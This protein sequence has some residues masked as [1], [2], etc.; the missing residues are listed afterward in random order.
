MI[1]LWKN[2]AKKNKTLCQR[3]IKELLQEDDE[4]NTEEFQKL[5]NSY[6]IEKPPE[7]VAEIVS[8]IKQNKAATPKLQYKRRNNRIRAFKAKHR[9]GRGLAK[10]SYKY[11]KEPPLPPVTQLPTQGKG[12]RITAYL[13]EMHAVTLRDWNKVYN[14]WGTKGPPDEIEWIKKHGKHLEKNKKPNL[15]KLPP[16]TGEDLHKQIR[17]TNKDTAA[18]TCGWRA[19]ELKLLPA[20]LLEPYA[21]LLDKIEKGAPWPQGLLYAVVALLAKHGVIAQNALQQ[22]PITISSVLYRIYSSLRYKHLCLWVKGWIHP[23]LKGGIP[24]GEVR[25]ITVELGIDLEQTAAKAA[26][27]EQKGED[28]SHNTLY[29]ANEDV[30][31]CYDTMNRKQLF[32]AATKLGADETFMNSQERFYNQLKRTFRY[33]RSIGPWFG[34]QTSILQG[35]ALSQHWVNIDAS[36]WAWT[37]Q[38]AGEYDKYGN[39]KPN[40]NG[41]PHLTVNG[42]IDDKGLRG[43]DKDRGQNGVLASD[44]YHQDSGQVPEYTK[45][46]AWHDSPRSSFKPQPLKFGPVPLKLIPMEKVLGVEHQY[47]G[48]QTRGVQDERGDKAAAAAK[49]VAVLPITT[50]LKARLIDTAV[51]PVY[52][53]GAEN[54]GVIQK[55]LDSVTRQVDQAIRGNKYQARAPELYWALVQNGPRIHPESACDVTAVRET[56]RILQKQNNLWNKVKETWTTLQELTIDTKV[57]GPIGRLNQIFK[58]R[59]WKWD[60]SFT[61]NQENGKSLNLKN[62]HYKH[63]KEQAEEASRLRLIQKFHNPKRRVRKDMEGLQIPDFQATTALLKGRVPYKL[64]IAEGA[65]KTILGSIISGAFIPLSGLTM[66]TCWHDVRCPFCKMQVRENK[67]H[68]FWICPAW[69]KEREPYINMLKGRGVKF[70]KDGTPSNSEF[71]QAMLCCGIINEDPQITKE[72]GKLKAEH[73]TPQPAPIRSEKDR[74]KEAREN[75]RLKAASDGSG[76][77]PREGR[78]R[79]CGYS[80]YFGP[81]HP[82]NVSLPL[83]GQ[84]QTTPRAEL[85]AIL[86]IFPSL[87]E[88]ITL[89]VDCSYVVNGYHLLQETGEVPAGA[90]QDLWKT[91]KKQVSKLPEKEW[92]EVQK[93]NAHLTLKDVKQGKITKQHFDLNE[94]A[95]STAKEGAKQNLVPE[96]VAKQ[97]Y[98]RVALATIT[99]KMFLKIIMTRKPEFEELKKKFPIEKEGTGERYQEYLKNTIYTKQQEKQISITMERGDNTQKFGFYGEW[100]PQQGHLQI[101]TVNKGSIAENAGLQIDDIILGTNQE[102]MIS[103]TVDQWEKVVRTE[104][105]LEMLIKRMETVPDDTPK[106]P[107]KD[108]SGIESQDDEE[109]EEQSKDIE[110]LWEEK[111]DD[112]LREEEQNEPGDEWNLLENP[113]EEDDENNSAPGKPRAESKRKEE[114]AATQMNKEKERKKEIQKG[115]LIEEPGEGQVEN[116]GEKEADDPTDTQP[117]N[118]NE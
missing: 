37:V 1:N 112:I 90:H 113:W 26:L 53:F 102:D 9:Q 64:K 89:L 115:T 23:A 118:K 75:G 116:I 71:T 86:E 59:N 84:Q 82:W 7:T 32:T 39:H 105:K 74:Q 11:V 78:I 110:M 18:G 62:D 21:Q 29:G 30:W 73:Y 94:G 42:F 69:A 27:Q 45:S 55:S 68:V 25:D 76:C 109:Q 101:Q 107:S 12:S 104:R 46:N 66:A 17:A 98:R 3:I 87:Q 100:V 34:T 40:P 96:E 48:R 63:I 16:L 51:L 13:P 81:D 15:W 72:Q 52:V 24:T 41:K 77:H 61:I 92:L 22:R 83:R 108:L 10:D 8:L 49:R 6:E 44:Q 35:C 28:P 43:M 14:R 58:K 99:Q 2:I 117:E 106:E 97:L 50:K 79:R 19:Y 60:K 114:K 54:Y 4:T 57:Q 88:P 95:D 111:W 47:M 80:L 31:K 85:R 93:V 56:I 65:E 103:I 5:E 20:I 70:N 33:G 91:I 67:I 36:M 38:E